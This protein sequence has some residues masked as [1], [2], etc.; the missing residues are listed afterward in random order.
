MIDA[1]QFAELKAEPMDTSQL[2]RWLSGKMPRRILML[3]FGGPLPGG[4]AGLDLDGEYFDDATDIYG[5]L[6]Q[7]RLSRQRLVDWHHD[8]DPTGTMKGADLGRVVFDETPESDGVWADFWAN[9]GE[10]RRNL[11]AALERRGVAL[12]GSTQAYHPAVKKAADGHIE[13]WPVIRHTITTSPQNTMAIVPALKA[14]LTSGLSFDE[15]GIPAIQ[16]AMLGLDAAT[17][18]LLLTLPAAADPSADAGD[19]AAKAGR[20]LSKK[21]EDDLR[22]ALRILSELFSRGA[23]TPPLEESTK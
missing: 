12:Y 2:D 14:V 5:P 10:K 17:R 8:Q 9:A 6:P 11:I 23:F 16:A 21:N 3:P 7:L 22:E 15:V 4:K 19:G 13:V 1:K 20:V 18:D